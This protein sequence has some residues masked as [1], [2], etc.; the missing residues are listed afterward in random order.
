[1][2][3]AK[4]QKFATVLFAAYS[5]IE[6]M[7]DTGKQIKSITIDVEQSNLFRGELNG[8]VN[9]KNRSR[10]PVTVKVDESGKATVKFSGKEQQI[11]PTA[12]AA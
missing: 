3:N 9:F 12:A 8:M 11:Y 7:N 2:L 5:V 6:G 4:L 10:R 1:M